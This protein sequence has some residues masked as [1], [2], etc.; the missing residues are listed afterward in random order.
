VG[1]RSSPTANVGRSET[2]WKPNELNDIVLS[3]HGSQGRRV[4]GQKLNHGEEVDYDCHWQQ[5]R[6]TT[7]LASTQCH[8]SSLGPWLFEYLSSVGWSH[9]IDRRWSEEERWRRLER[10]M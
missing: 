4:E 2:A 10:D 8:V 7:T 6:F 1:V 3:S 5:P 9:V